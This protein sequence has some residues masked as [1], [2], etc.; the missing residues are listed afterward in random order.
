MC[1]DLSMAQRLRRDAKSCFQ[2]SISLF[3]T[4]V[5]SIT[6]LSRL[7]YLDKNLKMAEKMLR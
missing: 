3:P 5:P 2:G 6:H 1:S 7:Y 4:H